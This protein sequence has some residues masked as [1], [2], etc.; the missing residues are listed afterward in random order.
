[1][2]GAPARLSFQ[3]FMASRQRLFACLPGSFAAVPRAFV[4][5]RRALVAF[6]G[7]AV[8]F[9]GFTCVPSSQF[10]LR[11]RTRRL[12]PAQAGSM[13]ARRPGLPP[14]GMTLEGRKPGLSPLP[15][16][17]ERRIAGFVK[18][19]QALPELLLGG[20]AARLQLPS[21]R[22]QVAGGRRGRRRCL[23][24]GLSMPGPGVQLQAEE[25]R[26]GHHGRVHQAHPDDRSASHACV[27]AVS[28]TTGDVQRTAGLYTA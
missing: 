26:R 12:A 27:S 15:L 20:R 16:G 24:D 19:P 25:Q 8:V 4:S 1:V 2:F 5:I 11:V 17:L 28:L 9:R 23:R 14:G 13:L 7:V 21:F 6:L 10:A 18:L 3:R 22:F